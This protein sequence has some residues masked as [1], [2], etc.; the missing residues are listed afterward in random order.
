[1]YVPPLADAGATYVVSPLIPE[2]VTGLLVES[3]GAT[4]VLT[5]HLSAISPEWNQRIGT[6]KNVEWPKSARF[7]G[8]K[9]NDGMTNQ[10]LMVPGAL[11]YLD[12]SFAANNDV[13]MAMLENRDGHFVLPTDTSA[14]ASLGEATMPPDFRL[15]ITDPEGNTVE[16]IAGIP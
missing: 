7:V 2:E 11:G 8:A 4:A 14:Q 1:M 15:F 10:I 5:A 9:G 16:F 13:G 6:G 12:Y 3:S